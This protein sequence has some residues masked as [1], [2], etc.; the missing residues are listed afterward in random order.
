MPTT[1]SS[2]QG[3][4]RRKSRSQTALI[5]PFKDCVDTFGKFAGQRYYRP[6]DG[7]VNGYI[8]FNWPIG[9]APKSTHRVDD[10]PDKDPSEATKLSKDMVTYQRQ[11]S[12]SSEASSSSSSGCPALSP[13]AVPISAPPPSRSLSVT[14]STLAAESSLAYGGATGR[15]RLAPPHFGQ[16]TAMDPID[17]RF[18]SFCKSSQ[19]S[20][21]YTLL[22][23]FHLTLCFPKTSKIGARVEACSKARISGLPILPRC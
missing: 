5:S 15:P 6:T 19:P 4:R 9:G 10:V 3:H 20:Y 13:K 11:S 12:A 1:D 21:F 22:H 16:E 2:S 7:K 8:K 17:R 18:W 23:V 14:S